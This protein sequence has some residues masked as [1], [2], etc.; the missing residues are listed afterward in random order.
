MLDTS[1]NTTSASSS[2]EVLAQDTGDAPEI[3]PDQ[4]MQDIAEQVDAIFAG[5]ALQ[6][7]ADEQFGL[8]I[9]DPQTELAR[10]SDPTYDIEDGAA[11]IH[12]LQERA[13]KAV[14]HALRE[15]TKDT[16]THAIEEKFIALTLT[17]AHQ[18]KATEVGNM[19]RAL[20]QELKSASD[21]EQI[22]SRVADSLHMNMPDI[23]SEIGYVSNPDE[24]AGHVR[25]YIDKIKRYRDLSLKNAQQTPTRKSAAK[26]LIA[27]YE[28]LQLKT[29]WDNAQD[30]RLEAAEQRSTLQKQALERLSV[31]ASELEL[32][33]TLEELKD[34]AGEFGIRLP[35][36]AAD[37]HIAISNP[38]EVER[39]EYGALN[40]LAAAKQN[41]T[42]EHVA[43]AVRA[44]FAYRKVSK[45]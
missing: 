26:A 20:L 3:T 2:D 36:I 27:A 38:D 9:A 6:A 16:I 18:N 17:V 19:I 10:I 39:Y 43:D 1:H 12:E 29:A 24:D 15:P 30:K 8:S 44:I 40:A 13:D 37:P 7:L 23:T 45:K 4:K 42:P 11:H 28:C 34:I 25:E 31:V 21:P 35:A 22:A 32:A 5:D 33:T 41:P 14:D